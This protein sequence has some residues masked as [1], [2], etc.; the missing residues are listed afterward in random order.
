ML[1]T[2]RSIDHSLNAKLP[3][4]IV[5]FVST[6]VMKTDRQKGEAYKWIGSYMPEWQLNVT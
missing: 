5:Y 6:E 1:D 3:G 2:L 4:F